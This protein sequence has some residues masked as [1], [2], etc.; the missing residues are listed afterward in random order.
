MSPALRVSSEKQLYKQRDAL[1]ILAWGNIIFCLKSTGDC[2]IIFY[3]TLSGISLY[4][5]T[6]VYIVPRL[7]S[8]PC[9]GYIIFRRKKF[10]AD[11][12]RV[13]FYSGE[14]SICVPTSQPWI[15]FMAIFPE[16]PDFFLDCQCKTHE[17]FILRNTHTIL[18]SHLSKDCLDWL[19]APVYPSWWQIT[20]ASVIPNWE[21]S[22]MLPHRLL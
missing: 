15:T 6:K 8:I 11:W 7:L 16:K 12:V 14:N 4:N 20:W 5:T 22:Q 18:F 3:I 17:R 2:H 10:F 19:E 9:S 13:L 21:S 1:T